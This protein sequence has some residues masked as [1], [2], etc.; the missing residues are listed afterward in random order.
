MLQ[1][2]SASRTPQ[3]IKGPELYLAQPGR[4]CPNPIAVSDHARDLLK[5]N[6]CHFKCGAGSFQ[7][8]RLSRQRRM[9]A[10]G[11]E[12]LGRLAELALRPN[13]TVLLPV[14]VTA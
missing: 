12:E 13:V 3:V 5:L 11:G 10:R 8:R 14:L 9:Q 4:T 1:A 7:K 6:E 2:R